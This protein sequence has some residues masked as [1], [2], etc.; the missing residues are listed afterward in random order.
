MSTSTATAKTNPSL[1]QSSEHNGVLYN[2]YKRGSA[3]A[4]PVN[5]PALMGTYIMTTIYDAEPSQHAYR[6]NLLDAITTAC[7][8]FAGQI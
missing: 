1:I 6:Q 5:T 4:T 3:A 2:L 8:L 7:A